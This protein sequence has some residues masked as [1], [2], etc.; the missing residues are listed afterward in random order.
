MDS[1]VEQLQVIQDFYT[2]LRSFIHRMTTNEDEAIRNISGQKRAKTPT[3][4]FLLIPL[5]LA[6][7]E[8]PKD[9]V[10]Q[11][12]LLTILVGRYALHYD[13]AFDQ[14][15]PANHALSLLT[16]LKERINLYFLAY[17]GDSCRR[18]SSSFDSSLIRSMSAVSNEFLSICP[19]REIRDLLKSVYLDQGERRHSLL[20]LV[21]EAAEELNVVSLQPEWRVALANLMAAIQLFDDASDL[22][23][24]KLC[25][26]QTPLLAII[27]NNKSTLHA[28]LKH[29]C[30]IF[31]EYLKEAEVAY[32]P[33]NR[34]W[35]IYLKAL[36]QEGESF[37]IGTTIGH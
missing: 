3:L 10:E 9:K 8:L 18:L 24:D 2:G 30:C 20:T 13:D 6:S 33:L 17:P 22:L 23:I 26:R 11:L 12:T 25:D 1:F 32:N 29:C 5:L 27:A 36:R 35:P 28:I 19:E 31:S 4:Q 37:S 14:V 15:M 7:E 16:I 34:H 21:L